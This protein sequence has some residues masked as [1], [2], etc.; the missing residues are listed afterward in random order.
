VPA[1][2]GVSHEPPSQNLESH[3]PKRG[4]R[5]KGYTIQAARVKAKRKEELLNDIATS[6][7]QSCQEMMS[8][9]NTLDTLIE[10]KKDMRGILEL[11]IEKSC[12]RQRVKRNRLLCSNHSGTTSP[13]AP[14]EEHIVASL[15]Q[16][17]KM[18]QPLNISEGLSLA[19][20]LIEGTKWEKELLSFKER[21]G[22]KHL[23][24]DGQKNP[25]LVRNLASSRICCVC[26]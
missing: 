8:K 17:A 7:R 6:W 14:I 5:P 24:S 10:E 20:S 13:M 19:N 23:T 25:L 1:V 26:R 18:R 2:V 3:C 9:R 22:W 4:G 15:S 21:K 12:I 16:M 11:I